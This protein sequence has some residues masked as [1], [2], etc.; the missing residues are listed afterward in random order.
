MFNTLRMQFGG[1][2]CFAHSADQAGN[3][4]VHAL[5]ADARRSAHGPNGGHHPPH[6]AALQFY[7]DQLSRSNL[8]EPDLRFRR[9]GSNREQGILFLVREDLELKDDEILPPPLL[10]HGRT[11]DDAPAGEVEERD[12]FW[13]AD[14]ARLGMSGLKAGCV[15]KTV[16]APDSLLARFDLRGGTLSTGDVERS[17]GSPVQAIFLDPTV[18]PAASLTT[19]RQS[20]ALWSEW[21]VPVGPSEVTILLTSFDTGDQRRLVLSCE[22]L[23]MGDSL[24][25]SVKNVTMNDL[26]EVSD[27]IEPG[28]DPGMRGSHFDLHYRLAQTMPAP[29]W[30]PDPGTV[31]DGKPLCPPGQ[32]MVGP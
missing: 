4:T 28:M 12:F 1:I 14:F 21:E 17:G 18:N 30:V 27:I 6:V 26:F 19:Y 32:L 2:V 25:A 7:T 9:P 16:P 22:G 31:T 23:P 10:I 15:D 24:W 3:K 11:N 8:L 20:L 29:A 13:V 5:L